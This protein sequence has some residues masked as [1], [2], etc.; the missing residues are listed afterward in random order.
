MIDNTIK[1]GIF[2]CF[3]DSPGPLGAR[4]VA[5]RLKIKRSTVLRYCHATTFIEKVD[6]VDVGSYKT[7]IN[8]FK[9]VGEV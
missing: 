3:V 8:V 5:R 2:K 1:T 7:S 6:P 9:Y 4:T